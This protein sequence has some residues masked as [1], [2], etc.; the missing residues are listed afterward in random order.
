MLASAQDAIVDG[1]QSAIRNNLYPRVAG[2]AG[3][4]GP[5]NPQSFRRRSQLEPNRS[6][7]LMSS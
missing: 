2:A 4:A 3:K 1:A 5:T 6:S 7:L